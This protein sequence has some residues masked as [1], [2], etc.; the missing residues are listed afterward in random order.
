MA[1]RLNV[2]LPGG[3][4]AA[5]A[6]VGPA[7]ARESVIKPLEKMNKNGELSFIQGDEGV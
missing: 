3:I 1:E 6:G 5:R 4:S 2:E 7:G